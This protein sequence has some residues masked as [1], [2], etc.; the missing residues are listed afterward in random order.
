MQSNQFSQDTDQ[1]TDIQQ[2]YF[3]KKKSKRAYLNLRGIN[4][5]TGYLILSHLLGLHSK[6]TWEKVLVNA[7][8][9]TGNYSETEDITM[10]Q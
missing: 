5:W 10:G 4:C 6:S 2:W 7:M 1:D 8:H 9:L 3:V